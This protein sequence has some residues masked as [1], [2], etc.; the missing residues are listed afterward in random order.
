M[1]KEADDLDGSCSY[2]PCTGLFIVNYCDH[3][4]VVVVDGYTAWI[5]GHNVGDEYLGK[6]PV[7][8]HWCDTHVRI[9]GSVVLE[10]QL[11]FVVDWLWATDREIPGLS[12]NAVAS[13]RGNKAMLTIP[14][15]PADKAETALLMFLHAINSAQ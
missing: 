11:S 5:G 8:G 6:D 7:F 12:W 13:E 10:S 1:E 14:S 15:G 3:R 4:K 2:C 9:S